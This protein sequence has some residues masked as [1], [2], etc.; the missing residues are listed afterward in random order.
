M[1]SVAEISE[2]VDRYRNWLRDR[3]AVRELHSDWVEITTPFV[4]RHND[5]IQIYAK[6]DGDNFRLTDDGNTI[7]DLHLSGC[8][9]DTPKRKEFLQVAINGFSVDNKDDVLSVKAAPE[10]FAA[11]KHALVQAILAVN[12]LFYTSSAMVRSLFRE[13]VEAWLRLM[14]IRFLPNVQFS[15]KSGYVHHFDFGIPASR[16]APE[17]LIK[18]INNPTKD[19]AQ[20]LIFSWLDTRDTRPQDSAAIAVLND[21]ERGVT[22]SVL[23]ALRQYNV[24]PVLWSARDKSF[25]ELA[26]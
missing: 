24:Q 8:N 6:K 16:H 4:D 13:D 2:L 11:R 26:A 7:R 23:E 25:E 3:T 1:T 10:N 17:R 14:E 19:A 5:Y 21:N 18:A 12:D 9:L 20:S 22:E 15:G